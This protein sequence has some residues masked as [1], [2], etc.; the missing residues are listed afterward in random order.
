M[1]P[2]MAALLAGARFHLGQM[3]EQKRER[4][5]PFAV[6]K[7]LNTAAHS[8]LGYRSIADAREFAV[9]PTAWVQTAVFRL[10]SSVTA[11]PLRRL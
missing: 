9:S 10:P 4:R 8:F 11:P 3:H 6:A 7:P 5:F 1:P 2:S